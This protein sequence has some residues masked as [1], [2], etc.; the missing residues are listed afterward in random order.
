M[1]IVVK[2]LIYSDLIYALI[3]GIIMFFGLVGIG[4]TQP[5][6]TSVPLWCFFYVL[7]SV[8]FDGLVIVALVFPSTQLINSLL[9]ASAGAATG[10]GVHSAH[11]VIEERRNAKLIAREKEHNKEL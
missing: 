3:G 4:I 11:H 1:K 8:I 2:C 9:G 10:L 5:R 7:I 6:G